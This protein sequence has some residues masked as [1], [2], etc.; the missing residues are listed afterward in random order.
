MDASPEML[1]LNAERTRDP[2]VR[3]VVSDIFALRPDAAWDVVFF[4]FWLSHVPLG[5]FDSF[6]DL[7]SGLLTPQGRAFFVDE[8]A[9]T[10]WAEEWLDEP[11]GLVQR[12]LRN[13][14]VHRA[15]KVLWRPPELEQR[16]RGLG[17][18]AQVHGAGPF[19]WGCASRSTG[20]DAGGLT[21]PS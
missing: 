18:D 12:R 19:Y 21:A 11:T 5:R 20:R 17:W 7:V 14:S 16:L 15:V 8:A 13:G 1:R 4:G 10:F 2:R 6:W 9:H 3:Y